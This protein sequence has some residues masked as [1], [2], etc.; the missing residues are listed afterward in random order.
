MFLIVSILNALTLIA[1]VYTMD[2]RY[3]YLS[4]VLLLLQS[5]IAAID[6]RKHATEVPKANF[7]KSTK[8]R[9]KSIT[10]GKGKKK[11]AP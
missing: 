7:A 4:S 11:K 2:K 3:L 8:P 10:N 6:R 5:I 9:S 1:T